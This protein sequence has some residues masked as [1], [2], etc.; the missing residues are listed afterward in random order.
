MSNH[1]GVNILDICYY[2]L[3]VVNRIRSDMRILV[4]E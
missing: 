4:G 1:R 2:E 3:L